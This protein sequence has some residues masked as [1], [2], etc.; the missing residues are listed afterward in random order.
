MRIFVMTVALVS[1]LVGAGV[2]A[3]EAAKVEKV[4]LTNKLIDGKKVWEPG[5]I[6]VAAGSEIEL[7]LTNTLADPHGFTV[8]GL[9]ENVVVAGNET[10][11]VKVAATKAGT[12]KF[13]CQLHPAHVGGEIVVK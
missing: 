8:P 10:K 7:T 11:T 4:T 5:A 9:V 6:K 3:T 12:Y 2:Q 1:L 13:S